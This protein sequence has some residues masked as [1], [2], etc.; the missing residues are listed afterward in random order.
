MSYPLCQTQ[1]LWAMR[2]EGTGGQAFFIDEVWHG[3]LVPGESCS[4]RFDDC[5]AGNK[6]G[7]AVDHGLGLDEFSVFACNFKP[8]ERLGVARS[9]SAPRVIETQANLA[10]FDSHR[11]VKGTGVDEVILAI[12][13][14][15]SPEREA[16][17]NVLFVFRMDV[18]DI[19][20]VRGDGHAG[21]GNIQSGGLGLPELGESEFIAAVAIGRDLHEVEGGVGAEED[22]APGLDERLHFV[23]VGHAVAVVRF[24]LVPS[25]AAHGEGGDGINHRVVEQRG[26][27]RVVADHLTDEFD[28]RLIAPGTGQADAISF[29]GT[30]DTEFHGVGVARHAA[31][32][33]RVDDAHGDGVGAGFDKFGGML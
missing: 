13:F 18:G 16:L 22:V 1:D 4:G 20:N 6:D 27:I 29:L 8:V 33:K 24:A 15:K 14:R 31:G 2:S 23:E 32:A 25:G 11:F 5:V 10:A 26:T 19:T 12:V 7:V 3:F 30:G 9:K 28:A 17:A 21:V